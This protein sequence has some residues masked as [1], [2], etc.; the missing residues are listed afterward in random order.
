MTLTVKL[1]IGA[2]VCTLI[3]LI[4]FKVIDT[5][6]MQ[7]APVDTVTDTVR[8]SIGITGY[9]VSPGNYLLD[10]NSTMS[11]LIEKAGGVNDKADTRAFFP[12]ALVEKNVQYYIPPRY[13]PTDVCSAD[14]IQKVNIN[15]FTDPEDLTYIEGI[16]KTIA[17]SIIDY[18]DTNGLFQ[19]LESLMN[20]SGIGNSTY[21]KLRNYIIL[22]D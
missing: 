9:V 19:T 7:T 16:G 6:F 12:E 10:E 4:A 14:E 5:N 3:G 21:T 11:D 13:N 20:V 17:T 1:L 2:V 18:R 22:V 15:S 8:N